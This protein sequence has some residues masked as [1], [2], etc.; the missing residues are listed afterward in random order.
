LSTLAIF[1][2]VLIISQLIRLTELLVAFGFSLENVF[3]PIIFVAVPFLSI[4][5]PM[6]FLFAVMLA[7]SR[8]SSDGEF[9]ALLASG[10]SVKKAILPIFMIASFLFVVG[11]MISTNLEA[12]GRR[13]Y[14]SFAY[15]KTQSEL[16]NLMRSKVQPKVFVE[17][18]LGFVLYAD[19]VS[20]D[21]TNYKKILLTPQASSGK[22]D[23]FTLSAPEGKIEGSVE[24]GQ[25]LLTLTN[26]FGFGSKENSFK[27]FRFKSLKVDLLRLFRDQIFGGN[28]LKNDYESMNFSEISAWL[29]A[30]RSEGKSQ[31]PEFRKANHLFHKR[32][33]VPFSTLIF[34][35]FGMVFGISDQRRPKGSA[36]GLSICVIIFSYLFS[37]GFQWL[38]V[39]G[40]MPAILAAWGAN[41][42][43]L[44]VGLFLVYQRNRLPISE[45]LIAW[46]NLKN[47]RLS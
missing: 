14:L 36:Y 37:T 11:A 27:S 41:L 8:M 28:S 2:S 35:L 18:F 7:F 30:Q 33:A 20:P 31:T 29:T 5:I 32:F 39:N 1:S 42:I 38:S 21:K 9:I 6:A 47:I 22:I 44:P 17:N 34:F 26:G 19:E 46:K 3:L 43:L 25:M 13:E 10:Y 23:G 4:T 40:Y 15:R 24:K 16:D 45:S 12:W